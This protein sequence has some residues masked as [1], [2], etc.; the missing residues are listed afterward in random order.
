M[1]TID[2]ELL[3]KEFINI[4]ENEQ[5]IVLATSA[6]SKVTAR[7]MS[8]VNDGSDIY[9][10]T[11]NTSEKYRQIESNRNIAFAISNVQIKAVA[12]IQKHPQET[13]IFINL[14]KLKFPRYFDLYTNNKDEV[15]IKAIPTKVTF[16]KYIAGKPCREILDFETK[17]AYREY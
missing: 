6:G 1:N 4:L 5:S 17:K 11:S 3:T 16:F 12:E 14:F 2:F 9:F 7:T 8:H 13:P 10:Q 15:L